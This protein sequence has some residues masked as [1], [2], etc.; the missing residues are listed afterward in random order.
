MELL[1]VVS[2]M[3][4]SHVS[5]TFCSPLALLS[6][7][8]YTHKKPRN[9]RYIN[10]QGKR[11]KLFRLH[12]QRSGCIRRKL[13]RTTTIGKENLKKDNTL[14]PARSQWGDTELFMLIIGLS[15][16]SPKRIQPS[17]TYPWYLVY[18]P[19]GK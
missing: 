7:T 11:I 10:R 15:W 12:E 6:R 2:C 14:Q 8:W 18:Q 13:A 1:G 5:T 16:M 9:G 17:D 3:S 4:M 19:E